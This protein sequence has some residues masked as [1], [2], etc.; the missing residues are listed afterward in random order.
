MDPE[1]AV[2]AM[3]FSGLKVAIVHYWLVT[4]RGGEKVIESLLKLFPDA[5]I[6]TLFYEPSVCQTH[7]KNNRVFTSI[8]DHGLLRK[9]YQKLFPLYPAGIRSLKLRKTYDLI[10]SSESGPA[11][12]IRNPEGT[13]HLCY[14]HTPMRYCWGFTQAYL[15]TMPRWMR[16]GARW[17]FNRLRTWDRSTIDN[18]DRYVANSKN[19]AER[20]RR[21]YGKTAA[22]CYPPIALELFDGELPANKREYYLSFGAITPYK[23]IEL[24]IETFNRLD[25]RLIV[26]GTGSERNRL[27][28]MAK[29]NIEFKGALPLS[30]VTEIIRNA[31]ALL[32]PGEEDF[33]MI[34][35][36]VMSQGV[37]VIAYKKGGALETVVEDRVR[38]EHSSGMFF[39]EPTVASLLDTLVQFEILEKRFDPDWIRN[40]ARTFGEDHFLRV[41][42]G[43]I[44]SLLDHHGA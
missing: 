15:D 19:V 40:H 21:F 39:D 29:G 35:L 28:R 3:G 27:E 37:P 6:Y 43:Q 31:R 5:D 33:G 24:L 41:M 34:P 2:T 1:N 10:L 18:V 26:V 11:K 13:P 25:R 16:W 22:V 23:N 38:P 14:I 8:L 44:R 17:Q 20:V 32:F 9:H 36:E 4:W 12:G 30:A 7:F 42:S